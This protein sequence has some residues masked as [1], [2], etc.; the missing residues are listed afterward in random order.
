MWG[1]SLLQPLPLPR[2]LSGRGAGKGPIVPSALVWWLVYQLVLYLPNRFSNFPVALLLLSSPYKVYRLM[3]HEHCQCLRCLRHSHPRHLFSCHPLLR[4][5]HLPY[6]SPCEADVASRPEP[7]PGATGLLG[8]PT[9]SCPSTATGRA[10]LCRGL[11]TGLAVFSPPALFCDV[12]DAQCVR[13]DLDRHHRG[14][15]RLR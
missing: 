11:T 10:P 14:G 13:E 4:V 5:P 9:A 12:L 8:R 15:L 1:D 2:S 6:F 7:L 3:H